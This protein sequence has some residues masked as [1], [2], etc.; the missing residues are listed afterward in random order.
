MKGRDTGSLLHG[1]PGAASPRIPSAASHSC[2]VTAATLTFQRICVQPAP[3]GGP[4]APHVLIWVGTLHPASRI[5]HVAFPA[6]PPAG[7]PGKHTGLVIKA[8]LGFGC[9]EP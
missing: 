3:R 9:S 5:G 8:K 1:V 6:P 7:S 4:R 2:S